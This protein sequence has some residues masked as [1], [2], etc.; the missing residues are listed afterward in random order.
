MPE[1]KISI[2]G[3]AFDVA[4]QAGEEPF[5]EAAAKLLD[6]EA[7]VLVD[8]VGR[9]PEARM[10]LMAGLMLADKTANLQAQIQS[11]A[12]QAAPPSGEAAAQKSAP[13]VDLEGM[14]SGLAALAAQAEDLADRAEPG[15]AP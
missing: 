11:G 5:L 2:G 1:V 14:L 13:A 6:D 8:Q 12:G 7:Q 15:G 3:R 10:L 9:M 4:C